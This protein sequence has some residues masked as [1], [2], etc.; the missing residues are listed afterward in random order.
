MS[1]FVAVAFKTSDEQQPYL[2]VGAESKMIS[3]YFDRDG[4]LVEKTNEDSDKIL[5]IEDK[6]VGIAGKYNEDILQ[7]FIDFIRK[8]NCEIKKLSKMAFKYLQGLI[9]TNK[10][11]NEQRCSVIIG[12]CNN[13]NP[14]IAHIIVDCDRPE[15]NIC[16]VREPEPGTFIIEFCGCGENSED[17]QGK[18]VKNLMQCWNGNLPSVRKTVVEYLKNAALL[19]PKFCNQNIRV[20]VKK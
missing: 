7:L 1:L 5:E 9:N 16:N 17:L 6:L 8:N 20:K 2:L 10:F 14:Q 15:T 4:N 3:L 13:H 12:C 11:F 19:Y 18:F